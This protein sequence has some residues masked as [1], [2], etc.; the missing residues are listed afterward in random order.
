M[1]GGSGER[2]RGWVFTRNKQDNEVNLPPRWEQLPQGATW[3]FYQKEMAAREHYQGAIYFRQPL[4]LQTVVA[5]LGGG[6]VHVEVMHGTPQDQVEYCGKEQTRVDGPWELGE[7]PAQGRRNDLEAAAE[8]ARVSGIK[9]VAQDHPTTFI[10]YA[11][12]LREYAF[13]MQELAIPNM[14][15]VSVHWLWGDTGGGKSWAARQFNQG[16][17]YFAVND[18]EKIWFD[19]YD[20]EEVLIIEEFKGYYPINKLHVLLDIYKCRAEVKGAHSWAQWNTVFV[21]SREHP[22]TYYSAVENPWDVSGRHPSELQRR[23]TSIH[24]VTGNHNAGTAQWD[25]APPGL[26]TV[27]SIPLHPQTV[28]EQIAEEPESADGWATAPTAA[29]DLTNDDDIQD[30]QLANDDEF[31]RLLDEIQ[32][33]EYCQM[34]G[35]PYSPGMVL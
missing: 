15:D 26:D 14:R 9:R 31:E 7:R 25:T 12:G 28:G 6:G 18:E 33:R 21:T 20:G 19:G 35:I 3:M 8:T 29:V 5:R 16:A 1:P 34:M 23:I 30:A 27:P 4:R 2:A 11:K 24:H 22:Q 10:K 17:S 13:I 32:T